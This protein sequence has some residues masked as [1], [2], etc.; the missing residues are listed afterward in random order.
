MAHRQLE[1]FQ[2][3]GLLARPA[4]SLPHETIRQKLSQHRTTRLFWA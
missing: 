3:T 1:P 2:P 4:E